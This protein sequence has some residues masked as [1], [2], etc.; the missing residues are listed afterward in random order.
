MNIFAKIKLPCMYENVNYLLY[1]LLKH[2]YLLNNIF[3]TY[4]KLIMIY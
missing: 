3:P 1:V 2:Y 4:Q